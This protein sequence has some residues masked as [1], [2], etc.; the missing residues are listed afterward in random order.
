MNFCGP[1]LDRA[2]VPSTFACRQGKG[3]LA[4][5]FHAQKRCLRNPWFVKM[6]VRRYFDS[7]DHIILM[8]L[9]ARKFKGPGVLGLFERTL[10]GYHTQPGKGLPIGALTSQ[11]F[12]NFYLDGF[13]RGLLAQGL[14]KSH[15][16]YMDDVVCWC[17]SRQAARTV[18]KF[19]RVWLSEKR[20]LELKANA[21]VHRSVLGMSFLGFL[22]QPN[23]LSLSKRRKIRYR[24]ALD[25]W[26][27]AYR[28]GNISALELQNNYSSVHSVV[29]HAESRAWRCRLLQIRE[30]L[31]V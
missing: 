21:Q 4:A 30:P 5:V 25:G 19:A 22:I 16:R 24:K 11:Y 27:R 18:L 14:V 23:R 10:A 3:S 12:A 17:E 7:I 28:A 8:R 26:E 15:V 2:L 31:E 6:D 1:I 9:L 29:A 20:K 13:D